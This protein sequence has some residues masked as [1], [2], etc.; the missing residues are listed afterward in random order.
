MDCFLNVLSNK[1]EQ[2]RDGTALRFYPG[3]LLVRL[4][5]LSFLISIGSPDSAVPAYPGLH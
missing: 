4:W 5:K 2:A 3:L 1:K